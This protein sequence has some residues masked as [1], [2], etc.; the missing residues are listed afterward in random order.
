[1]SD[2]AGIL[3]KW[4]FI[5]GIILAK[6]QFDQTYIFWNMPILIFSPVQIIMGHPLIPD[7]YEDFIA[8]EISLLN[9]GKFTANT[10]F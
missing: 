10:D 3:P 7:F 4:F 5:R 8:F 1:M 6:G 9:I 2:Q